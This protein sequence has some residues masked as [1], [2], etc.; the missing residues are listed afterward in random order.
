ML[1]CAK[2][3][4]ATDVVSAFQGPSILKRKLYKDKIDMGKNY[5]YNNEMLLLFGYRNTS[6]NFAPN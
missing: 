1:M 4:A 2:W 6:H 3:G 5:Y